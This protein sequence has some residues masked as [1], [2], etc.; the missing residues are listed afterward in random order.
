MVTCKVINRLLIVLLVWMVL[1]VGCGWLGNERTPS[2]VLPNEKL[3]F[4]NEILTDA[5]IPIMQF[6]VYPTVKTVYQIEPKKIG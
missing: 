3:S 1:W 4:Y 5:P 6:T 2:H